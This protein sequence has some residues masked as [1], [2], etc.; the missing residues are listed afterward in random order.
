MEK[1]TAD[2]GMD[3]FHAVSQLNQT[4]S[5]SIILSGAERR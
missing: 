2:I 3:V 1:L 5:V 4:H